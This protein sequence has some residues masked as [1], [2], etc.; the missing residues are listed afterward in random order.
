MKAEQIDNFSQI[1]KQA[2]G[3]NSKRLQLTLFQ[4]F[5]MRRRLQWIYQQGENVPGRDSI[6]QRFLKFMVALKEANY[7]G[8]EFLRFEVD[9]ALERAGVSDPL[10]TSNPMI[11]AVTH[12]ETELMKVK[13]L[14]KL[15]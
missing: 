13:R 9:L 1:V 8:F 14:L 5:G 3:G 6:V 15:T 7:H 12:L 4:R 2:I 11:D 10:L